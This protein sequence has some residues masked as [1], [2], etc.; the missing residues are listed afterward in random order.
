MLRVTQM[1][2]K[3]GVVDKFVE[4]YGPGLSALGLADRAT[5]ANMAP[6]YGA[7]DRLL[8]DRRRD[9][10]AT[11][12]A[13]AASAETVELVERYTK[14]QGLFRTD[15]TPDPEFTS[16]I[17]LDLA[18]ASS[19]AWPG[20]KR[21]QDL[22]PLRSLRQNFAVSLPGL[23]QPERA[24]APRRDFASA[25]AGR[26]AN[27]GGRAGAASTAAPCGAVPHQRR[28]RTSCSD[29][30]VVIAAITV[31][32]QHLE[33]V[34]DDRRRPARQE[35]GG[36]GAPEPALGQDQPRARLARGHR[37]PRATPG[38]R[39]YLEQLGFQT[40]GYGCTTC[41][42]NSGPLPEPVARAI[43]EH[44]PRGGGGPVRQPEL[45]GPDPPA[46]ARQLPRLADAG[47]GLRAARAGSTST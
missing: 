14:E 46:G 37:L 36:E 4:F 23:M 20:P 5:I 22:V 42:G 33:S 18:H 34:G 8:P 24:A 2:R 10:R 30:A 29:G 9:A 40:V 28:G 25:E 17:E 39:P 27:E 43:E 45:R 19:R 7:T 47:G 16:T 41:I 35:G 12:G 31:V 32:H 21:P 38:S 44:S 1:L 15:A 6:E 26:W 13:P 3:K 11:C